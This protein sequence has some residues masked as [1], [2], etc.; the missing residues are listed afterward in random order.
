MSPKSTYVLTF[1]TYMDLF[2]EV[3][4]TCMPLSICELAPTNC[5]FLDQNEASG[6]EH[7]AGMLHRFSAFV[8]D[9]RE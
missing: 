5:T 4:G 7:K 1:G 2:I 6:L 8:W 9:E 3:Q